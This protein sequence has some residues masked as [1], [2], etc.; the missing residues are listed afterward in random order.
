[1]TEV[2]FHT[3]VAD[4][5][6]FA[7]RLLRKAYRKGARV[8]VT[9]PPPLLGSLDRELWTFE[10]LEF[11][12]HVRLSG[13]PPSAQ[14]A[15]TPIWLV[16]GE[17]PAGSPDVLVNLGAALPSDL[18][19]LRRVIEIVSAD[20]DDEQA[21]RQRWRSYKARGIAITHHPSVGRA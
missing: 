1:V 18:S 19:A 12:P 10:P 20:I 3:G 16:D 15:R 4:P 14:A 7:C 13:E 21:G 8:V 5:L 6:G 2:E 17:L 11:V 9:A